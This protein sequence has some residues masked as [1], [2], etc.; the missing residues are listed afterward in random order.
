MR[1]FLAEEEQQNHTEV[2]WTAPR[3][4]T[5]RFACRKPRSGPGNDPVQRG[6]DVDLTPA[7]TRAAG[8]DEVTAGR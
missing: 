6:G 3:S 1:R 8:G 2:D 7:V 4:V 5:Y